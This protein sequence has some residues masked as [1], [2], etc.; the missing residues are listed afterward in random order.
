[1]LFLNQLKIDQFQWFFWGQ[2]RSGHHA[3]IE[4]LFQDKQY[5]HYNNAKVSN[6][7][8]IAHDII[9]KNGCKIVSFEGKIKFK[10]KNDAQKI[11]VIR[12]PYNMYA[13]R[14]KMKR[15]S[16]KFNLKSWSNCLRPDEWINHAEEFLQLNNC[17]FTDKICYDFWLSNENYR[18]KLKQ[19]YNLDK[20]EIQEKISSFGGGS[21]FTESKDFLNRWQEFQK[22]AE[23]IR[24]LE[25][26][27][28]KILWQEISNTYANYLD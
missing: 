26:K 10:I 4:W 16:K 2:Q 18:E 27:K 5:I 13:S 6:N 20:I 8:V 17:Y 1:M 28:I 23:F 24:I 7:F 19:K 22:D 14:L 25:N 9:G 3:V 15:E 12:N 11:L 21:S